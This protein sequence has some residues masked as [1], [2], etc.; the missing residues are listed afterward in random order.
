MGDGICEVCIGAAKA[1]ARIA[2]GGYKRE[3]YEREAPKA[4][5]VDEIAAALKTLK[6]P[7]EANWQQI[8]TQYRK[9]VL[10]YNADRPQSE[11]QR[12]VNVERLKRI[13]A[14]YAALKA[15]YEQKAA[16]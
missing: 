13:N 6:L 5:P 15:H 14:A 10:K 11:K 4:K 3:T 1:R 9:L 12:T 7:R 2:P 16:A 8:K